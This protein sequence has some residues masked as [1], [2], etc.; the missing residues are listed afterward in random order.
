MLRRLL[1]IA[2]SAAAVLGVMAPAASAAAP[3]SRCGTYGVGLGPGGPT[4]YWGNCTGRQTLINVYLNRP[5]QPATLVR[6][7]CVA[8][9]ATAVLGTSLGWTY[10]YSGQDTGQ[11]C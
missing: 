9:D 10:S 3:P 2:A 7:E 6:Q 5:G 1:V 8:V 4:Y 11:N